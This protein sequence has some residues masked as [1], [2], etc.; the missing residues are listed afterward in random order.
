V[1]EIHCLWKSIKNN[2]PQKPQGL[3][4]I[5]VTEGFPTIRISGKAE[6]FLAQ[7]LKPQSSYR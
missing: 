2:V 7:Q 4:G 3:S 5:K 6:G 1:P